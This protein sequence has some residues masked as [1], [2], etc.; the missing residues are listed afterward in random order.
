[1]RKENEIYAYPKE[2][3]VVNRNLNQYQNKKEYWKRNS[4]IYVGTRKIANYG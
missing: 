2:K 3:E 4:N 1:M